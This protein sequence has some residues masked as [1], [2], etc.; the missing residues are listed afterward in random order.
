MKKRIFAL[1]LAI[2]CL[3]SMVVAPANAAEIAAENTTALTGACP[4]GCGLVLANV[5]WKPYKGEVNTGH[6]YL[7]GDYSQ[8]EELT[9][10]S[11]NSVVLDLRGYILT[12]TAKERLFTVNGYLGIL[13]SVGGGRL[14]SRTADTYNG[15]II[16][17]VDNETAG[18]LVE[19]YS[20]TITPRSDATRSKG[21]GLVGL[22]DGATFRMYGGLLLNG[23]ATSSGG[24]IHAETSTSTVEI[25]GGSIV[26]NQSTGSGGSI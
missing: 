13:D 26:G 11:G 18:S 20:G 3:A 21:G 5:D 6:Y 22:G 9:I 15:G 8:A 7:E 16:R 24:A 2:S 10:I 19:L 25:L 17:I 14:T 12:I 4:C 1:L 23:N